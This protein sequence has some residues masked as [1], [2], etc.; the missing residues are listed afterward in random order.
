MGLKRLRFCLVTAAAFFVTY[1]CIK[2]LLGAGGALAA[3]HVA[4]VTHMLAASLGEVVSLLLFCH[5]P[6]FFSQ[7]WFE[8]FTFYSAVVFVERPF[9]LVVSPPRLCCFPTAMRPPQTPPACGLTF[10]TDTHTTV[11][12]GSR[13]ECVVLAVDSGIQLGAST[14]HSQHFPSTRCVN[15]VPLPLI[16]SSA[17][18]AQAPRL[19]RFS[20]GCMGPK[21]TAEQFPQSILARSAGANRRFRHVRGPNVFT[22][23]LR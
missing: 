1:D 11:Q 23:A 22:L 19:C 8:I 5:S 3:P 6:N 18:P 7:L 12:E 15:K 21:A 14:V 17:F 16:D 20:L 10:T 2:S 13:G 9:A 4:P